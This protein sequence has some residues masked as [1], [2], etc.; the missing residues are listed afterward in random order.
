MIQL[1]RRYRFSASHRLHSPALSDERNREVYGKCNHPFGHGHNYVL[2]VAVR[3]PV[4]SE[5]GRMVSVEGLDRLVAEHVLSALDYRNLNAE[6]A[7]LSG[8]APTTENLAL[9]IRRRLLA[10]WK[11][12][13]PGSFPVLAGLRILETP[14]NIFDLTEEA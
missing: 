6:V 13:F 7:G 14:R 4:D 2:E 10:N 5:I 9:E 12:A 8:L 3:G 1:A 11:N